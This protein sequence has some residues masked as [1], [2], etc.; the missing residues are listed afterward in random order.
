MWEDSQASEERALWNCWSCDYH[1]LSDVNWGWRCMIWGEVPLDGNW[2]L[3]DLLARSPQLTGL[4]SSAWLKDFQK[5]RA[6]LSWSTFAPDQTELW[7]LLFC[8]LPPRSPSP[9]HYFPLLH[10]L[11]L[12]GWGGMDFSFLQRTPIFSVHCLFRHDAIAHLVDH[13]TVK[14]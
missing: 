10:L 7:A 11:P 14:T 4:S 2:I 8:A 5:S 12:L 1:R 6:A 3:H 13:R 9:H